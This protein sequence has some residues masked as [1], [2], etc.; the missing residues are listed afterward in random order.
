MD[1]SGRTGSAPHPAA[2]HPEDTKDG[3]VDGTVDE[4]SHGAA[5]RWTVRILVL[6]V[7][8]VVLAVGVGLGPRHYAKEGLGVTALVGFALLTAGLVAAVWASLRILGAV[9]RRWWV[10]VIP[11]LLVATYLSLWTLGQAVAASYPPRPALGERTPAD[12]GMTYRDVSFP[13]GDGVDLAGWYVPTRNGAAVALMHGAGSTRSD[14]LEHAAVLAENGYGVLLFDARGHGESEGPGH[15]F[16]WYGESDVRGAVDFLTEQPK[17]SPAR[18]GLVGL[19]MGGESAIGAAGVDDRVAAVVA[20][21]ATHRVAADKGYLAEAYGARGELQQ[22]IDSVTY[23]LTDLLSTA[24]QPDPLRQSV[25]SA[26]TRPEPADFLL[27]AGG[28]VPEEGEAAGYIQDAASDAVQ[29][30]T[31]PDAGHTQGLDAAPA[32]WEERVVAFLD[33]SLGQGI[34]DGRRPASG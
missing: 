12:L 32:E 27:I 7:G 24:P 6:V 9:R 23:G 16:G 4:A 20:E 11:L 21:G 15:D 18:V 3:T 2:R 10:L 25:S 19:S 5:R 28:G 17:V 29:T 8:L 31:V 30:W 34:T 22:R 26:A 1:R 14:V 33:D 13:S